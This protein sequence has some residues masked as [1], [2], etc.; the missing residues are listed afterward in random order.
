M[1]TKLRAVVLALGLVALLPAR[2][3]AQ[4]TDAAVAEAARL[5][6][7]AVAAT[8]RGDFAAAL[9][10]FHA[11]YAANPLPDVLYNVGM[12]QKALGQFPEAANTF[13]QY[14]VIVGDG[15]PADERAEFDAIL[16]D[17]VPRIGRISFEVSQDGSRVTVDGAEVDPGALGGWMAV[18]PGPHTVA[19]ERSGFEP[20]SV[21]VSAPAGEIATARLTL[22]P[23]AEAVP[24]PG[25]ADE[26]VSQTWFWVTAGAAAALGIAGAIT[27]GLELADEGDFT[28]AA[29]RCNAGNDS[30]CSEGRSIYADIEDEANATTALLVVAG[31]AAATALVLVFFTDWDGESPP[32]VAVGVA[33]VVGSGGSGAVL[34]A[35]LRF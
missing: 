17:L 14:V 34:G 22:V 35:A 1:N 9:Q 30:A 27:G 13:R 29:D 15:M 26:G 16:A 28:D 20:A 3:A 24:P 32:P 11:S 5:F 7:E 25:A 4:P 12:C 18:A 19:A 21:V 2:G 23:V 6:D 31:A 33:P 8:E 10:A